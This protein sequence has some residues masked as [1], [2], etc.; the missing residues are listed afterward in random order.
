LKAFSAD[1][2]YGGTAVTYC[3]ETL[4]KPLHISKK[5]KDG[6]AVL[7]KRWVVE[8]TFSWLGHFRRLSKAV[9]ILTATSE[10]M[11]HIAMLKITLA[12]CV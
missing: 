3:T 10:N 8:R 4:H 1:A 12:K 7:P 11:I 2:G 9:E 6:W 5:I